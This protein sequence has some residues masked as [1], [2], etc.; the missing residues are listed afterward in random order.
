[1][2]KG[3]LHAGFLWGKVTAPRDVY[4]ETSTSR[5]SC[6]LPRD[7]RGS[8]VNTLRAAEEV[9]EIEKKQVREDAKTQVQVARK[10]LRTLS[11]RMA[12]QCTRE[13]M[14][15]HFKIAGGRAS[16]SDNY[17]CKFDRNHT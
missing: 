9:G 1:M 17:H 5:H 14:T 11:K 8:Q 13:V 10:E 3:S 15:L 2:R 16:W 12:Q 7:E 4:R 6:L